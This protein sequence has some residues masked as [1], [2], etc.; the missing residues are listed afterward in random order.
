MSLQS[1]GLQLLLSF[2]YPSLHTLEIALLQYIKGFNDQSMIRKMLK[3]GQNI[4]WNACT[5]WTNVNKVTW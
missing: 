3:C 5:F 2:S 4:L 1:K